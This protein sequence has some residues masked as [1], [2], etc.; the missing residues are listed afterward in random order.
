LSLNINIQGLPQG[1]AV[2]NKVEASS[3]KVG[4]EVK[5]QSKKIAAKAPTTLHSQH[6][7]AAPRTHDVQEVSSHVHT[8]QTARQATAA[9]RTHDVQEA[10]KPARTTQTARQATAAPRTDDVQEESQPVRITQA[11]RQDQ[12]GDYAAVSREH[13]Q[14]EQEWDQRQQQQQQQR[15]AAARQARAPQRQIIPEDGLYVPMQERNA[16]VQD[17]E[18]SDSESQS[19]Q[20]LTARRQMPQRGQLLHQPYPYLNDGVARVPPPGPGDPNIWSGPSWM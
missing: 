7:A 12:V 9:P 19:Q 3:D 8:M 15:G 18:N 6:V 17:Q 13:E 1:A 2:T 5:V 10:S 4:T 16:P 11:P 20:T 14:W